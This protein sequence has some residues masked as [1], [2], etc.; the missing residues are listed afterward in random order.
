MSKR[1]KKNPNKTPAT[2][3]NA[4]KESDR[5]FYCAIANVM[6]S[7]AETEKY[8]LE[9]IEALWDKIN[10]TADK[11][12]SGTLKMEKVLLKIS[13]AGI[14]IG[15]I[16]RIQNSPRTM[17]DV[18]RNAKAAYKLA[19]AIMLYTL[20]VAEAFSHNELSELWARAVYKKDS[21]D[22]KYTTLRDVCDALLDDYGISVAAGVKL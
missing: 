11:I 21:I 5:A 14:D 17:A 16:S 3:E 22:R 20:I 8:T 4:A 7:I 18:K 19:C 1:Q 10:E 15:H 12:A 13:E 6:D 9:E 2:P